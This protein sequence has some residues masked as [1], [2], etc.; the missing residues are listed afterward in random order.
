M[1]KTKIILD[2]NEIPK[3]WYNILPDMPTPLSPPLNPATKEPIG[4]KDL[5]PLFPMEL[6][7]QEVSQER[8]IA[9]PDE[10]RDIYSLWRPSPLYRAHRLEAALKT[11]ARIYYKYEGVSPAGSHKPNTAVAQ[12]YY[13][14]KEGIERLATETGAGQ[15]GSA[16]A[17]ATTLFGL[18]CTVYMVKI[19]YQQKP[20]RKSLMHLW[21]ADV[22]PSPSDKTNAGKKILS[23]DPGSPGSLGI[24]ISEAIEDAATHD[25]TH[26][27]L[28]SVLNHVMLHQTVIGQETKEQLAQVEEYPDCIIGSVGG[29][30]NFAGL[31]FPFLMDKLA[32]TKDVEVVAV[33][34]TACPSLTGGEFRYDFGDTVGLTPLLKMYTM[35]HEY[36]PPAIHAGGLRYHGDSP[37]VSQL[38]ADKVIDAVA[39]SQTEV[40]KAGVTFARSEGIVPAPE[41]AHAIKCAIDK[42]LE[43]KKSGEKKTILFNLSGHGH[44][45]MSAYDTYFSGNMLDEPI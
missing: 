9:I 19:S 6:I 21:G 41:S 24:A 4:P 1:Q 34:P 14:M 45:D 32:G 16:L 22:I 36:V 29:G 26:Y 33:E 30:S 8:F 15:W 43:C 23:K 28:G 42:A 35:G 40:F 7:K 44:F 12:A 11:P 13:N 27:S 37:I 5:S 39:Y 3:K 17:L 10:V 2:E 31:S 25:D 20:Y 38:Y 18:K